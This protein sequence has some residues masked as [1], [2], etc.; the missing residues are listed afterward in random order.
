VLLL[1]VCLALLGAAD[2][3][4]AKVAPVLGAVDF[5]SRPYLEA[6]ITAY[7]YTSDQSSFELSTYADAG[8]GLALLDDDQ[9]DFSVTPSYTS[10]ASRWRQVPLGLYG[11]V[12]TINKNPQ[13]A[14]PLGYGI[15]PSFDMTM[16][17][18][19]YTGDITSWQ[20]PALYDFTGFT[21]MPQ[22][23]IVLLVRN[24]T[25]PAV[26]MASE[27]GVFARA[28][29]RLDTTGRFGAA[30]EA[31]GQLLL[32]TVLS[33]VSPSRVAVLAP[34]ANM[35][36]AA[37]TT[38][39]ALA[40]L[41]AAET[42]GKD[43]DANNLLAIQ[44]GAAGAIGFEAPSADSLARALNQFESEGSAETPYGLAID[45][46]GANISGSWP[47]AGMA[48]VMVAQDAS[49]S[50]C[51]YI[52]SLLK[53]LAWTQTNPAAIKLS[54]GGNTLTALT[55]TMRQRAIESMGLVRCDANSA[56]ATQY[57]LGVGPDTSAWRS[58][59]QSY[60]PS[61]S[62]FNLRFETTANR[63]ARDSVAAGDVDF[64]GFIMGTADN[65]TASVRVLPAG[66]RA[67]GCAA[68]SGVRISLSLDLLAD[69]L[70]GT[71]TKWND[72]RLAAPADAGSGD[73]RFV[74]DTGG[75]PTLSGGP[76]GGPVNQAIFAALSALRPGLA[77]TV[78]S[79]GV[80]KWPV[81]L[82]NT[83]VV[84]AGD[85]TNK[86]LA[87][88]NGLGCDF[89]DNL[90]STRQLL[91]ADMITA[92][93]AKRAVSASGSDVGRALQLTIASL[94]EQSST[95]LSNS[96][97]LLSGVSCAGCW[98]LGAWMGL[99]VKQ[100][101][102]SDCGR[103]QAMLDWAWWMASDSDST[104]V[105][106][107]AVATFGSVSS[108]T[109]G[110]AAVLSSL[111][112]MVCRNE[113]VF[114]QY[115]C[116]SDANTTLCSDHGTCTTTSA[117]ST[118]SKKVCSC[119]A[120]WEGTLCATSVESSSGSND[121]TTWIVGVAVGLPVAMLLLLCVIVLVVVAL[122]LIVLP[123]WRQR[124]DWWVPLDEIQVTEKLGEGANGEVWRG[125]WR[126]SQVA[127]KYLREDV[128]R[129][130]VGVTAF[131]DEV[132]VCSRLRHPNV[133]LF[134]G[135]CMARP[136]PVILF[137]YMPLGSLWDLLG[138]ELI[139]VI[140]F[141]L[142]LKIVHQAARGM[143]FLH[144]SGIVH[145]DLKSLNLLLDNKWNTKVADFGLTRMASAS[146]G[147]AAPTRNTSPMS[148]HWMAPE[149]F[150]NPERAHASADVYAFG[151]IMWE[152]LTR[153]RP[154]RNLAPQAI[155]MS[156]AI[157][158]RRPEVPEMTDLAGP[159]AGPF[160][161]YKSLMQGAWAH[162]PEMRPDF[163]E[164]LNGIGNMR[165]L[166]EGKS[167]AFS[168][169]D[170]SSSSAS[171]SLKNHRNFA[172][173]G[174][175]RSIRTN[176]S[177]ATS[178]SAGDVVGVWDATRG[179]YGHNQGPD[180]TVKGWYGAD[181]SGA[182][183][184]A[185]VIV[186][187]TGANILWEERPNE[188]ARALP[189]FNK[190]V[191]EQLAA[192]GGVESSGMPMSADL[193]RD[194]RGGAPRKDAFVTPPPAVFSLVF[195]TI[196]AAL[197]WCAA[198][199]E[200]LV[201]YNWD[202]RL[203]ESDPA[204]EETGVDDVVLFRGLCA[205]MG[206][207]WGVARRSVDPLSNTA[208]YLGPATESAVRTCMAA[209]GG[210]ILVTR[211]TARRLARDE[212]MPPNVSFV[213]TRKAR[214][215]YQA[216][217]ARLAGRW[218]GHFTP[219]TIVPLASD[220][221]APVQHTE[222]GRRVPSAARGKAVETSDDE[223]DD[224]DAASFIED[225]SDR[226][227]DEGDN[228]DCPDAG[229]PQGSQ[230]AR[231]ARPFLGSTYLCR[232]FIRWSQLTLGEEIGVGSF[233]RVYVG[234][235]ARSKGQKVAIKLFLNNKR[236]SDTGLIDLL[237]EASILSRLQEGTQHNVLVFMGMCIEP[238]R[239][240]IVTEY[241][242]RGSLRSVLDDRSSKLT[243][244]MRLNML[245]H[246][247]RGVAFLHGQQPDPVFHRDLKSSNLLVD[248]DGCVKV[249]DFG[250]ARTRD[251]GAAMTRC[252][253]PAWTAPEIL[254]GEQF[255][256]RSDVYS[257][258]IIMWEVLTRAH[259]YSDRNFMAVAIDVNEGKRPVVP[260]D[261]P[262]DYRKLM[263]RCWHSDVAKRPSM[264]AVLDAISAMI[265]DKELPV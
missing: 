237:K 76:L 232:W 167:S 187:V 221:S 188:M 174:S 172:S 99:A 106:T 229:T 140:P 126:G 184:L 118:G 134:M 264:D 251:E 240:C 194:T 168:S 192:H 178:T 265:A 82:R 256:D 74:T 113:P 212:Q 34:G 9:V 258:G 66:L 87:L 165:Q 2:L 135:A 179:A 78:S 12:M 217:P 171:S 114:S 152:V 75:D 154:Y 5:V 158:G 159:L 242:P 65:V 115:A 183:G 250:F 8:T 123:R 222:S 96:M 185:C 54:T 145:R 138:N 238:E 36:T 16:V 214:A 70:L 92:Q 202:D 173:T 83:T 121:N 191:R 80:L 14:E 111:A 13:P 228:D 163:A 239:L 47:L 122:F 216:V 230:M 116:L 245:R 94:P 176:S 19:F 97:R 79:P 200:A 86:L 149:L 62:A 45:I 71:I 193:D 204:R 23:D 125:V 262:R 68:A 128:V 247:A 48:M 190:I 254:R 32:P 104:D 93:S 51:V 11:L 155:P 146:R 37:S 38:D 18:A 1:A 29:A 25:D 17:V 44:L 7:S 205:R 249:C 26:E 260:T 186:D 148:V 22:G 261:C 147:F 223:N 151:I 177:V 175:S 241:M 81:E 119:E 112:T 170:C 209:Q 69:I 28:L 153:D 4:T 227:D 157:D 72:T 3:T 263:K 231:A 142:K 144:S 98:P 10:S 166:I 160:A 40:Y 77:A 246:A 143:H 85:V 64:A 162:D 102:V 235:W 141:L 63:K 164:I 220:P 207:A 248:D 236:Q 161:T 59:A 226:S 109:W 67:I 156:V 42:A 210:Q 108:A 39:R 233:G 41:M 195:G 129:T 255:T 218:F 61:S 182:N 130:N 110:R 127:V 6:A 20:D 244:N 257:F 57:I 58:W 100:G 252:G 120:G 180:A 33:F 84:G 46:A 89:V 196:G 150:E 117:S 197:R 103:T 253:T 208:C 225:D 60:D 101:N 169:T 201:N 73:I 219:V 53:F 206:V 88:P 90:L 15:P 181:P 52:N 215:Y 30:Y 133:V 234:E 259:P 56:L 139:P 224:H 124:P 91:V 131:Y 137:E 95:D 199:Q 55:T 198:T 21:D 105:S 132:N 24:Y 43:L 243:W 31:H 27:T 35:F 50:E 211:T 213:S 203:L 189:A 107:M 136:Q 49:A